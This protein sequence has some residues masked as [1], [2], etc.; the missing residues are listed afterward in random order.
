M[1]RMTSTRIAG[2]VTQGYRRVR[3]L[4]LLSVLALAV[5]VPRSASAVT[6]PNLY[7]HGGPIFNMTVNVLFCGIGEDPASVAARDVIMQELYTLEGY[8]DGWPSNTPPGLQP[9]IR[10]YGAWGIIAG[11]TVIDAT[12][13]PLRSSP[14]PRP[15]GPPAFTYM[16][17]D[18]VQARITYEQQQ[19]SAGGGTL[20]PPDDPSQFTLVIVPDGI[21]QLDPQGH[22]A[23]GYHSTVGNHGRYA[24]VGLSDPVGVSHEI[25]EAATDP[26][27]PDGWSTDEDLGFTHWE[28]AD[29]PC[30]SVP[31]QYSIATFT[32]NMAFENYPGYGTDSCQVFVPEQYAPIAVAQ[33]GNEAHVYT[34]DGNG[35]LHK[36]YGAYSYQAYQTLDLG[37]PV[38]NVVS[39]ASK[40]SVI[41]YYGIDIV[42]VRGTDNQLWIWEGGSW[43]PMGSPDGQGFYGNPSAVVWNGGDNINVFMLGRDLKLW[44]IG[45]VGAWGTW[46][47]GLVDGVSVFNGPPV[48]ISRSASTIDVFLSD[49]NLGLTRYWW[50][51]SVWNGPQRFG[52]L[53]STGPKSSSPIEVVAPP[54]VASWGFDNLELFVKGD[55]GPSAASFVHTKYNGTTW[56]AWDSR[57]DIAVG[58][59]GSVGTVSWGANRVDAFVIDTGKQTMFHTSRTGSIWANENHTPF[60]AP[61]PGDP[62]SGATGDPVV[63]SPAP[64]QLDVYYRDISGNLHQSHYNGGWTHLLLGLGLVH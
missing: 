14:P 43:I 30:G 32:S 50:D 40:P 6:A 57:S 8:L 60:I 64:G 48:A 26:V 12:P 62:Y 53:L 22:Y 31:A 46:G 21:S 36:T 5:L 35:S 24:I 18:D 16:H 61:I 51:G 34:V 33:T 7:W 23:P 20:L 10:S 25:L 27:W 55:L 11:A 15:G 4:A 13:I 29:D 63:T 9:A 3:R 39:A 45:Y 42:F 41:Q 2:T 28:G 56:S 47:W 17:Y 58:N 44:S 54:S 59:S 49:I 19:A 38:P 52:K 37:W 1:T